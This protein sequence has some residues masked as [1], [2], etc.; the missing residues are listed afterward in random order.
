MAR[1]HE[2]VCPHQGCENA[3][4]YSCPYCAMMWCGEHLEEHTGGCPAK[5]IVEAHGANEEL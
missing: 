1:W 5:R 4:E 2:E 3:A